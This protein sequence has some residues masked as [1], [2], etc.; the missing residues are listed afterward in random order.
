MAARGVK[1]ATKLDIFATLAAEDQYG[2][3]VTGNSSTVTLTLSS[4]TFEG[5]STTATA[6]AVSGVAT[7]STLKIDVAGSYSVAATDGA[8]AAS[9]A[10]SSFTISPAA[11]SKVV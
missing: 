1:V 7:F 9:G 3:V 6:V 11:A 8:L 5:G 4:G 2:N 10:S